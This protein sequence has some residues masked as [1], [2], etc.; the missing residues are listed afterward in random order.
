MTRTSHTTLLEGLAEASPAERVAAAFEA[1]AAIDDPAVFIA[2]ADRD[3]ALAAIDESLPLAGLTFAVKNNIDV[4]GFDTTAGCP[5]Y[6]FRPDRSATVVRR[7]LDAGATCVGVTNLD[8][9]A[10][11]LVGVRSPYGEIGRAHV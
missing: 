3:R 6:A 7:L 11:G 4:E 9:F 5:S 2:T 1:V 8:Q 10:T